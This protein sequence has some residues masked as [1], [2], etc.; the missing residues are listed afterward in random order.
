LVHSLR[1]CSKIPKKTRKPLSLIHMENA[2][3]HTARATQE[4]LDV[5]WFKGTQQPP[6]SP[7]I[8]PS[9]FFFSVGWKPS[10][11]G[12]NIMGKMNYTK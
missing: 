5:S 6:Y 3:V 9:E 1:K 2:T 4:K 8:A 12:E 7:D 11:N 10:L